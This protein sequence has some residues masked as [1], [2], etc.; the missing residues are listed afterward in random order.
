M[1]DAV[2]MLRWVLIAY[3]FGQRVQVTGRKR[4]V[5]RKEQRSEGECESLVAKD[6]RGVFCPLESDP[7]CPLIV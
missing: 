2:K 4:R 1:Q 7:D 3:S 6:V 5:T